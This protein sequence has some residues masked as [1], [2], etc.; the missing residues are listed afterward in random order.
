MSTNVNT[1]VLDF[2]GEPIVEN[3][4]K[5]MVGEVLLNAVNAGSAA[6]EDHKTKTLRYLLGMR[7]AAAMMGDGN[8]ALTAS[9]KSL[10]LESVTR[11]YYPV[12]VG[13]V[14]ELLDPEALNA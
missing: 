14:T 1:P 12:V 7:I 13:R 6:D 9:E 10:I 11:L 5:L 2:K 3:G 8:L 4:A